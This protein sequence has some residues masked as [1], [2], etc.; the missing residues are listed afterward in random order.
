MRPYGIM[1]HA[2]GNLTDEEYIKKIAELGFSATFTGPFATDREQAVLSELLTKHDVTYE[3]IHAPFG[4][5]ND[6]WLDTPEGHEMF[7]ELCDSVDRCAA[8]SV[9][10]LVVHL[11]SGLNP[12]SITDLG[13]ARFT[14]LVDYAARKGIKI[15]F[16]N[17]RWLGNLCWVM[18]FLD[19]NT[20]GFCWDCGHEACFTPGKQF[21][22]LFGDRLICTHIHDNS[23]EFNA[24][25]HW[26]PFDGGVD[27]DRV[28][29]QIRESGY[30]GSLMLEVIGF[31]PRY[32]D[33]NVDVYLERA[34]EAAKKLVAMTDGGAQ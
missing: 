23:C 18:E 21:M 17:Q 14:C 9:P 24:D 13:R 19:P 33:M 2:I 3:T 20:V 10:I 32:R 6:I 11:S 22:P 31:R 29:R 30:K 25:D 4:H 26:L 1:M 15:A 16:E 12:P 27:F 34:A 7:R 5:I 28:T 8:A